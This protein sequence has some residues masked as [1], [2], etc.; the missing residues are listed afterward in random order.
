[1]EGNYVG[2]TYIDPTTTEDSLDL[3]LG[4][5]KRIVITREKKMEYSKSRTVGGNIV[6]DYLFEISAKNMKSA[7]VR[8][9]IEDQ[10]PVSQNGDIKVSMEE[11]SGGVFDA[12]TGKVQWK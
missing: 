10:L 11:L 8:L 7:A 12:V 3:S 5:D 9:V 1:F 2:T 6:R 4:R